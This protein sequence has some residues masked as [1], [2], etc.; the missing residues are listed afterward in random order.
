MDPAVLQRLLLVDL[1]LRRG[2]VPGGED[3]GGD[4][5]ARRLLPRPPPAPPTGETAS[6]GIVPVQDTRETLRGVKVY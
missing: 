3:L 5:V 4:Q 2:R 6:T 1:L